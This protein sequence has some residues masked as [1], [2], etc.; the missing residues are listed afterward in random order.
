MLRLVRNRGDLDGGPP[1][2]SKHAL[3][4][5]PG[6]GSA[7]LGGPTQRPWR[8]R[9]SALSTS[10]RPELDLTSGVCA[11][12]ARA[13]PGA[14]TGR[15]GRGPDVK[16]SIAGVGLHC[17]KVL[18]SPGTLP[19]TFGH[20]NRRLDLEPPAPPSRSGLATVLPRPS[21]RRRIHWRS[22]HP[23]PV[24]DTPGREFRPG[25]SPWRG[26][27]QVLRVSIPGASRELGA[28]CSPDNR[29]RRWPHAAGTGWPP[30]RTTSRPSAPSLVATLERV[31]RFPCLRAS[32]RVAGRENRALGDGRSAPAPSGLPT[33]A[34]PAPG[35]RL[36]CRCPASP[37]VAGPT[38]SWL[39]ESPL[40]FQRVGPLRK[41]AARPC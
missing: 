11:G 39:M 31:A 30:R 8:M 10:S 26:D 17:V 20:G 3:P 19:M 2:W 28:R 29:G 37:P 15:P 24:I 1:T 9:F 25:V 23:F 18:I 36:A 22:P 6:P 7:F 16:R 21:P 32:P 35:P 5:G 34:P 4:E 13:L 12:P 41:P 40:S 14:E 27:D 38:G 33:A